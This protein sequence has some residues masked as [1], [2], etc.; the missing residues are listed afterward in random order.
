MNV[1]EKLNN[2][3]IELQG[4]KLKKSGKNKFAGYEYYELQDFLPTIIELF[5]K[6][7]LCSVVS[8]SPETATMHLCNIEKPDEII[9]FHSPMAE[10]NLKGCHPIQNLG[11]VETYQRRYL[12]M[13]A[14]E[15]V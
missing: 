13:A 12:Y 8:Y 7:K 4:M 11:A 10:A 1:Y 3:R 15:I 9:T 14:L 2:C 6:Y 5:N